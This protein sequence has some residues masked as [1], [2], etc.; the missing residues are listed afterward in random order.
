MRNR[1]FHPTG[2]VSFCRKASNLSTE[3]NL[4][5]RYLDQL[6]VNVLPTIFFLICSSIITLYLSDIIYRAKFH[7][8]V[9]KP[10]QISH[11]TASQGSD[12]SFSNLGHSKGTP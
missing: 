5:K 4:L 3:N 10:A 7:S 11:S 6:L 9:L 8:T 12:V 1:A 2:F